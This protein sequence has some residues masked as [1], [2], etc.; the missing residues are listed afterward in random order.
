MLQGRGQSWGEV[1]SEGPP[2]LAAQA[3]RPQRSYV[4]RSICGRPG[5]LSLPSMQWLQEVGCV[6]ALVPG[7]GLPAGGG[8]P[9][10]EP[11]AHQMTPLTMADWSARMYLLLSRRQ[12]H[13]ALRTHWA[14]WLR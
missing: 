12:G 13:W 2:H 10:G 1:G 5:Q 6:S 3:R 4:P 9:P 7:W 14:L 11:R 8:R